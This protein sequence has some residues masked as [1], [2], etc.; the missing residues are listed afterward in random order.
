MDESPQYRDLV[1]RTT[2]LVTRANVRKST[3]Q[4]IA[5]KMDA[6][7]AER[8]I[9]ANAPGFARQRGISVERARESLRKSYRMAAATRW[10]GE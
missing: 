9:A 6:E 3:A 1:R 5:E 7:G 4:L 10:E 2:V 8:L